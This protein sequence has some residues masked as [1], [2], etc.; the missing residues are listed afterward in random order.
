VWR[1]FFFCPASP[2]FAGR[3]RVFA[4]RIFNAT[5][6]P[7]CRSKAQR[8]RACP[9]QAAVLGNTEIMPERVFLTERQSGKGAAEGAARMELS[10]Q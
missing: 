2:L 8:S 4:Q 5:V 10:L 3:Q 9:G 1:G 7:V 6:K